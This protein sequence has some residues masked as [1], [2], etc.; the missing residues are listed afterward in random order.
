MVELKH[1]K[2]LIGRAKYLMDKTANELTEE[3][4]KR[5]QSK[6]DEEYKERILMALEDANP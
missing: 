2:A 3:M 1:R 6:K 5:L 4:V